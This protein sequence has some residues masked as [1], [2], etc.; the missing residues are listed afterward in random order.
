MAVG[1]PPE[2]APF[3]KGR[4]RGGALLPTL[5]LAFAVFSGCGTTDLV[6]LTGSPRLNRCSGSD[7]PHPVA[8]RIYYLKSDGRFLDSDFDALWQSDREILQDDYLDHAER[9]LNPRSQLRVELQRKDDASEATA[10]GIMANFCDA[11][12]G[13]WRKVVPLA[14]GGKEIWIL[15]GERCLSIDM[16][17]GGS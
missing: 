14:G 7:D 8:V 11:Q 16:K 1:E 10:L 6:T 3:R 9:T 17:G 2:S 4:G 12:E 5:L 15:L 13:C